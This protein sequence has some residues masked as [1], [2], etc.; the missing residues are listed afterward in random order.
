MLHLS[1]I[2]IGNS[3]IRYKKKIEQNVFHIEANRKN[4]MSEKKGS[5][6]GWLKTIRE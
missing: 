3:V 6:Y 5:Y 1:K 4:Y 2:T